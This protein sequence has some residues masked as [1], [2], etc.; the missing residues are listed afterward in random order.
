[1]PQEMNPFLMA[2]LARQQQQAAEE[3]LSAQQA[4][5]GQSQLDAAQLAR[6]QANNGMAQTG[7]GGVPYGQTRQPGNAGA[8]FWDAYN[9]AALRKAQVGGGED[10][11]T[12]FGRSGVVSY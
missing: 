6:I 4:Q 11:G 1:M 8:A 5:Q 10:L 7:G 9:A 2:I 3:Q 12:M